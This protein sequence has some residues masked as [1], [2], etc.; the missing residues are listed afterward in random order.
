MCWGFPEDG[1]YTIIRSLSEKLETMIIELPSDQVLLYRAEQ[2]KEK[3]G[4]LRFYMTAQTEE[5]TKV[6]REAE[7]ASANACELC[8]S[9]ATQLNH[10]GWIV[11]RCVACVRKGLP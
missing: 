1:W 6:I 7:V 9:S 2:V 3:F 8:G 5:M 10:H 4:Q 11:T